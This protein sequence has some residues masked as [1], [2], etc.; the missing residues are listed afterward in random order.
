MLPSYR[1]QSTDFLLKYLSYE[2][3]THRQTTR[4]P[5]FIFGPPIKIEDSIFVYKLFEKRDIS[6][7]YS[8]DIP[9]VK[10]Y[11]NCNF[12]RVYIWEF[13]RVAG[14]TLRIN[15]FIPRDWFVFMNYDKKRK[16]SNI[17]WTTRKSPSLLPNCF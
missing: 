11:T 12:L 15:D 1:N 10:K 4:K 13:L 5:C 14:S 6:I 17:N 7:L 2:V 3:R 9:Y 8:A 16:Q